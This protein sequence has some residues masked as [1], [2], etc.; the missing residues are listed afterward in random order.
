M[1]KTLTILTVIAVLSFG[2]A[3][4]ARMMGGGPGGGGDAEWT[5]GRG[6]CGQG[7]GYMMGGYYK[8]VETQKLLNETVAQRRELHAKTFDYREAMRT[9]DFEKAGKL[10]KEI[11]ALEETLEKTLG[12]RPYGK[13]HAR[14]YG[15]GTEG[16]GPCAQ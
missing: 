16:R 7:T 4:S 5:G 14:G 10:E 6:P 12:E 13:E 15:R 3:A 9:G 1:R 8:N 2:A 11:D